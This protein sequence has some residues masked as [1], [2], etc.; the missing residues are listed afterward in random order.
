MIWEG[1]TVCTSNPIL[2]TKFSN[3]RV[4]TI[5]INFIIIIHL[6]CMEY[7][8]TLISYMSHTPVEMS[9]G[10][11]KLAWGLLYAT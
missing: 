5:I 3:Q 4:N 1:A 2:G 10:L 7:N 11:K 8:N 9:V 6:C